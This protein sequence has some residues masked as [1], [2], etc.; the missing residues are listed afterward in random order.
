VISTQLFIGSYL[1]PRVMGNTLNISPL[2]I[3]VS[4]IFWGWVWGPWG[5]VLSVPI[6]SM[7]AIIFENVE[8][9]K[10]IAVLMRS[11]PHRRITRLRTKKFA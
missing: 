5:M 3:I 11:E 4:L 8:A 6:T 2:L 7:I 9:L 1:A 10:P